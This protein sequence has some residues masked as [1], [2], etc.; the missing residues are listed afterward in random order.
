YKIG[1]FGPRQTRRATMAGWLL[2]Y[3]MT[4]YGRID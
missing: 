1:E 2:S 3:M 4:N